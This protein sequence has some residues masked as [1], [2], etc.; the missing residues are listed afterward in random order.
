MHWTGREF[1]LGEPPRSGPKPLYRLPELLAA[2]AMSPVFVVEG[3][4]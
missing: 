3:E 4:N 1:K 2:D